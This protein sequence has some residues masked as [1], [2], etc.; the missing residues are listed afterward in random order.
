MQLGVYEKLEVLKGDSDL[1]KYE[2]TPGSGVFRNSCSKCGS[3]CYK[4]LSNGA[5]VAPLGGKGAKPL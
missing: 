2:N 4:I 1:I 3:F 5:K